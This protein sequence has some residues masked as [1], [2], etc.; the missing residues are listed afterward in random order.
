MEKEKGFTLIELLV[1]VAVIA[2]L[3]S[4]VLVNLRGARD[5]A[6]D[7]RI[8]SALAQ[9]RPAA[10]IIISATGSY[11][12]VCASGVQPVNSLGSTQGLDVLQAELTGQG[13]T[14]ACRSSATNY[15]V[16]TTLKDTTAKWC[17]S[18][19][20]GRSC[21]T[22]VGFSCDAADSSCTCN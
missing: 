16:T 20:G 14:V 17:I 12:T 4:V 10:E 13:V 6:T 1:V 3:A 2:I 19:N 5:R 11:D 8:I 18:S 22:A 9:A 21:R 7:A 15:C